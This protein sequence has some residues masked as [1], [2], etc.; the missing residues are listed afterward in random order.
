MFLFTT[1]KLLKT[2]LITSS[3]F[4]TSW[5]RSRRWSSL[6]WLLSNFSALRTAVAIAIAAMSSKVLPPGGR[7]VPCSFIDCSFFERSFFSTYLLSCVIVTC[8]KGSPRINLINCFL[9]S[10][11]NICKLG[12]IFSSEWLFSDLLVY[13]FCHFWGRIMCN[14][15]YTKSVLALNK[16]LKLPILFQF[17]MCQNTYGV[18]IE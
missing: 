8:F 11:F 7:W 5:S 17:F 13:I 12:K 15:G 4:K 14:W 1:I 10:Y 9:R 16:K 18:P 3:I 6:L 2:T